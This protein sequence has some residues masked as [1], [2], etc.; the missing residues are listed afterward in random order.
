MSNFVVWV[1]DVGSI[2]KFNFWWCRAPSLK[3]ITCSKPGNDIDKFADGIVKDLKNGKKVAL[4]FECPLFIPVRD[5]TSELTKGRKGRDGKGDG[6]RPW[7]AGAGCASLAT[8]LTEC[9]WIFERMRQK[10]GEATQKY[11]RPTFDWKEF[12]PKDANL[13]IWEAFV[14][15]NAKGASD[16]DDA[17]IAA[18]TFWSKYHKCRNIVEASAVNEPAV[19]SLV[20]AALL[21][22]NLTKRISIL[23]EA[24][25][26]I[27]S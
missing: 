11:V 2:S 13:F 17:K 14:S 24:C 25:I 27:K 23:R 22:S 15:K 26:V 19:Y 4:G 6:N 5:K 12:I 21:R 1:A 18:R 20:G 9:V 10:F 8:G 16:R 7:S 3:Q